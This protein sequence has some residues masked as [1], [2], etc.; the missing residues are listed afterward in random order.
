[1][2]WTPIKMRLLKVG[3]GPVYTA[4]VTCLGEDVPDM[5]CKS[6]PADMFQTKKSGSE[7]IRGNASKITFESL[8]FGTHETSYCTCPET[9]N[10]NLKNKLKNPCDE[11]FTPFVPMLYFTF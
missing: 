3:I 7:D 6:I 9:Y 10:L 1:M 4:M 2:D 11:E 8:G 5:P